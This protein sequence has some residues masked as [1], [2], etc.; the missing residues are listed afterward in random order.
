MDFVTKLPILANW[1]GD[2]YDSIFVIVNR[3]TKMVYYE[4]VKVAIDVP[5]LV[6]VIINMVVRRNGVSE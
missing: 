5:G 6:E 1:K 3:F 2:S 4:P